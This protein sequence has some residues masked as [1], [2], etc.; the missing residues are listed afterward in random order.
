MMKQLIKILFL[1]YIICASNKAY[2]QAESDLPPKSG[3]DSAVDVQ[4]KALRKIGVDTVITFHRYGGAMIPLSMDT[5]LNHGI[6]DIFDNA[7]LLFRANNQWNILRFITFMSASPSKDGILQ[8]SPISISAD[9]LSEL[10][11]RIY[12]IEDEM[13]LSFISGTENNG[14][15]GYSQV[16]KHIPLFMK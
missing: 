12:K 8:S 13:F 9:S 16:F 7:Y 2:C 14:I 6:G 3:I 5:V 15:K 10:K 1:L 4:I 11:R